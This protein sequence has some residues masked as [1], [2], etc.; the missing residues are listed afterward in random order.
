[1]D[2]KP[3]RK[4][5]TESRRLPGSRSYVSDLWDIEKPATSWPPRKRD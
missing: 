1:M 5:A 2:S 4:S 3:E